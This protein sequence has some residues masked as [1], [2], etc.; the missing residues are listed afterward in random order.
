MCEFDS[1]QGQTMGVVLGK[2][3]SLVWF[4]GFKNE[5]HP[6]WGGWGCV[7]RHLSAAPLRLGRAHRCSVTTGSGR[8]RPRNPT[9]S[10]HTQGRTAAPAAPTS[11]PPCPSAPAGPGA[12]PSP[13]PLE[14]QPEEPT[15]QRGRHIAGAGRP[16]A[17]RRTRVIPRPPGG[18]EAGTEAAIAGVAAEAAAGAG[19]VGAAP[20]GRAGLAAAGSWR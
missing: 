2:T 13:A 12:R 1:N 8:W 9:G 15:N 19:R 18:L 5:G 17:N 11:D 6:R 3:R 4:Q 16:S 20:R 7:D 14:G 10:A